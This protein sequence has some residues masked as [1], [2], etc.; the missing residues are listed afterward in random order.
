MTSQVTYG[1][2]KDKKVDLKQVIFGMAVSGDGWVPIT[3]RGL[4]RG[5]YVR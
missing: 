2:S 5:I 3:G 1:H 4:H